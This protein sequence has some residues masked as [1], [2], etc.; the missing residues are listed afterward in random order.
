MLLTFILMAISIRAQS[1]VVN[2]KWLE[3]DVTQNG[4]KGMKIHVDFNVKNMKGKQGKVTI[5][6]TSRILPNNTDRYICSVYR[7][8]RY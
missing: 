2:N 7:T 1:V 5:S 4:V 8:L 6:P 3:H